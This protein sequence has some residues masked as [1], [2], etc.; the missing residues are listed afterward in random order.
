MTVH[1]KYFTQPKKQ[2]TP[3]VVSKVVRPKS[4]TPNR[5]HES[6]ARSLASET[7][8]IKAPINTFYKYPSKTRKVFFPVDPQRNVSD[9]SAFGVESIETNLLSRSQAIR[10]KRPHL[11]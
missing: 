3:R 11:T 10:K 4:S 8:K 7:P 1:S 6:S 2:F 5:P 9:D